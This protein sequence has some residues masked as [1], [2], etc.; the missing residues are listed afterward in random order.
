MAHVQNTFLAPGEIRI[1][2]QHVFAIFRHFE[3]AGD[4]TIDSLYMEQ[5]VYTSRCSE[6]AI[7][8]DDFSVLLAIIA[9]EEMVVLDADKRWLRRW[10]AQF[11]QGTDD[12]QP[13]YTTFLRLRTMA[14]HRA[15]WIMRHIFQNCVPEGHA[16][17]GDSVFR[18]P[19]QAQ[20]DY[21]ILYHHVFVHWAENH[22][23]F[24]HEDDDMTTMQMWKSTKHQLFPQICGS[25]VEC[26]GRADQFFAKHKY[27][28]YYIIHDVYDGKHPDDAHPYGNV[29]RYKRLMKLGTTL[30]LKCIRARFEPTCSMH[31]GYN[32]YY[33][34]ERP[35]HQSRLLKAQQAASTEQCI[36]LEDFEFPRAP[37]KLY[38]LSK[39]AHDTP[40]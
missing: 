6:M 27:P 22:T 24:V 19:S 16:G 35:F 5:N 2:L 25:I 15:H 7:V 9:E 26:V 13:D 38:E 32:F 36:F 30:N 14:H 39:N 1:N 4:S 17:H 29:A 11:P 31:I 28:Q 20:I 8:D 21:M 40:L 18:I 12:T 3:A 10:N 34:W 33:C 37:A 23:A